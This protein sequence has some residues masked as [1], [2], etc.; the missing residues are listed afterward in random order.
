M[1]H[2]ISQR[3]HRDCE[4]DR[5]HEPVPDMGSSRK[6]NGSYSY[7]HS[8][9]SEQLIPSAFQGVVRV[10]FHRTLY[11]MSTTSATGFRI[12][13]TRNYGVRLA[14]LRFSTSLRMIPF[15]SHSSID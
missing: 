10:C 8:C 7:R 15:N 13:E 3:Q 5:C 14:I 12:S 11:R 6:G 4:G 2:Y 1:V 9:T